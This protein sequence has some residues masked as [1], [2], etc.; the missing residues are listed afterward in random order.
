MLFKASLLLVGTLAVAS[1]ALEFVAATHESNNNTPLLKRQTQIC[2][3]VAPPVTCERSC[4][5]GY[6][7]CVYP[8]MCYNPGQGESCCSNGKYCR[9]GTYCTD[10]G[11]CPNSSTLEQCGATRRL[12][13]IP[14]PQAQVSTPASSPAPS[15]NSTRPA[16]T[17]TA[18]SRAI[19]PTGT[20]SP[21][22]PGRNTTVTTA[23]PP[24]QTKNAASQLQSAAMALGLGVMGA[25]AAL[26]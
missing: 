22:T 6:A 12:S 16:S 20:G 24:Q 17:S 4:G 11:C 5:I 26:M 23:A 15:T 3:A 14:P 13:V 25:L 19:I 1:Q 8:N 2:K 10:T 18:S 21:S 7:Q 9:A